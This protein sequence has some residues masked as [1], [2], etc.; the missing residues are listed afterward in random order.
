M[1]LIVGSTGHVGSMIARRLLAEGHPVRILVHPDSDYDDLT[2]AG[3]E[4]SLGDI[5]FPQSFGPAF[6]G[7]DT[8]IT[9]ASA[10]EPA[11]TMDSFQRLDL[12]GNRNL[13]DAAHAAGTRQFVFVSA[14][15]A[16]L[17]HPDPFFRA[18][19]RT[20][21]YL[22]VSGMPYTILAATPLLELWVE[23]LVERPM[24]ARHPVSVVG[25]GTRRHSLISRAD[26]AAIAA[27][28]VGHPAALNETL[29]VGG[30]DVIS[31]LDVV[32][33]LGEVM[34]RDLPVKHYDPGTPLPELSEELSR[35]AANFQAFDYT[36]DMT[37]I[38]E[39]FGVRLT[40]LDV[41]LSRIVGELVYS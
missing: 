35:I 6:R 37:S 27:A 24:R 13:I 30:P 9:T 19:G 31:W 15:G 25:S 7:V 26:L 8:V 40:P 14:L 39:T 16:D 38:T 4:P 10:T 2:R 18:K 36:V 32:A 20:E 34:G 33:R 29:A 3:C 5:K 41:T 12:E 28:V 21:A 1:I 11:D 23:R 22:R 17:E